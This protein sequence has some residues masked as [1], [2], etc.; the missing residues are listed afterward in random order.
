MTDDVPG[1]DKGAEAYRRGDY[2]AAFK[3]WRSHAEQGNP[4]AQYNLGSMYRDGQG[5]IE[6][7]VTAHMWFNIAASNGF[8]DAAKW[9]DELAGEMT[10]VELEKAQDLA[11]YH[12]V[13]KL[14]VSAAIKQNKE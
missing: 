3:E 5:V 11:R 4:Y 6:D 8:E 7:N 14:A 13:I 12:T 9:R 2:A 10:P 1:F